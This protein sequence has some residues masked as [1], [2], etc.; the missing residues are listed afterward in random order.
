MAVVNLIYGRKG[1]LLKFKVLELLAPLPYQAWERAA[2]WALTRFHRHTALAPRLFDAMS[3][4]RAQQDN[5]AF[6]LLIL[7]ELLATRGTRQ[8]FVRGRLLPRLMAGPYRFLC[9]SLFLVR[10]TW[11]TSATR[12]SRSTPSMRA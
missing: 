6:H 11:R 5:E 12:T 3:E 1:S 2:Y 7:E 8:G 9:W 10:P 4:A